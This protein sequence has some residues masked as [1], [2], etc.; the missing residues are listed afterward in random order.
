MATKYN[1]DGEID[2]IQLLGRV[3]ESLS[4]IEVKGDSVEFLHVGRIV[5]RQAIAGIKQIPE[6]KEKPKKR[7]EEN[8]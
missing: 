6:E 7:E 4:K 1:Y 2:L 5:L 3:D 8:T